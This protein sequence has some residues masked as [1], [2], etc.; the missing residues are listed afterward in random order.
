W[1]RQQRRSDSVALGREMLERE[2]KRLR[3]TVDDKV[4]NEVA[5]ELDCDDVEHL[6]AKLAEGQLSLTQLVR[7]FAPPK[8]TFAERLTQGPLRASDETSRG[9][10]DK[11]SAR[12]PRHRAEAVRGNPHQGHGQRDGVV[13]ALLPA[14]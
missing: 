1:L 6:Y 5:H 10:L 8:E 3:L 11:V 4:L 2:L 12:G 14:G 13:R 9:A 7:R